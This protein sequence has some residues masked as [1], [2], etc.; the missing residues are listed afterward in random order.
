ER[1]LELAA[2]VAR[3]AAPKPLVGFVIV[4]DGVVIGEGWHERPGQPH[5]ERN[6]LAAAG[7]ASGSTVYVSLEPCA[8]QGRTPSCADALVEAG[9]ARVV[10]AAQDPDPRT[11]GRGMARLR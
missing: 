5:A 7:D 3:T 2:R 6:A 1:C 4:R 11:D 9:V 8:H 10:A